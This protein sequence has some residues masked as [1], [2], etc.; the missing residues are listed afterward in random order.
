MRLDCRKYVITIWWCLIF[1]LISAMFFSTRIVNADGTEEYSLGDEIYQIGNIYEFSSIQVADGKDITQEGRIRWTFKNP[2]YQQKSAYLFFYIIGA[3][4]DG[5]KVTV[6]LQDKTKTDID[7]VVIEGQEGWN[8]IPFE[9]SEV[10]RFRIVLDLGVDADACITAVKILQKEPQSLNGLFAVTGVLF[11]VYL[12]GCGIFQIKRK[13]KGGLTDDIYEIFFRC[14]QRIYCIIGNLGEKPLRWLGKSGVL[15]LRRALWLAAAVG[16]WSLGCEAVRLNA[17]YH[18][19]I[20]FFSGMAMVFAAI[21]CWERNV[22]LRRWDTPIAK[23]YFA[24]ALSVLLSELILHKQFGGYGIFLLVVLPFL[25]F[26]RQNMKRPIALWKSVLSIILIWILLQMVYGL[27]A[28]TGILGWRVFETALAYQ[29]S[30]W[31]ILLKKLVR[32]ISLWGHSK[33]FSCFG[34]EQRYYGLMFFL[35]YKYGILV[36]GSWI[37]LVMTFFTELVKK[38]RRAAE[39]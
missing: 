27:S 1:A 38:G 16:I 37:V 8:V 2:Y 24:F 10:K 35:L 34:V 32:T 4:S 18:K 22:C 15:F 26:M 12:V 3:D 29:T 6:R 21:L 13:K 5:A 14:L 11:V 25:M 7:R 36:F 31:L 30:D 39:E 20:L 17:E 28:G 19:Y 23:S 9:G 33:K